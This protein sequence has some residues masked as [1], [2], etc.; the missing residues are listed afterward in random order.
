MYVMLCCCPNL[1]DL[2]LCFVSFFIHFLAP[3]FT[4]VWV[5]FYRNL[6]LF[7]VAHFNKWTF[8]VHS[9]LCAIQ[10]WA[11]YL[12]FRGNLYNCALL[13]SIFTSSSNW[14]FASSLIIVITN[15]KRESI[16]TVHTTLRSIDRWIIPIKSNKYAAIPS[17][18]VR[19]QVSA[20]SISWMKNAEFD[21]LM[22][23]P[24]E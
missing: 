19:L 23:Y 21:I 15:E 4:R 24:I 11:C 12:P 17:T 1:C 16:N 3:H 20:L 5:Y 18:C 9:H 7:I 10:I 13:L 8:A 14:P 2:T 22:E 6:F